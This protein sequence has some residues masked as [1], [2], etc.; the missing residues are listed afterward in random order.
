MI[1]NFSCISFAFRNLSSI[2]FDI[3]AQQHDSTIVAKHSHQMSLN[4]NSL[5]KNYQ[6]IQC[7]HQVSTTSRM[8]VDI[9]QLI[10]SILFPSTDQE[11]VQ[12]DI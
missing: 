9:V 12:L 3:E 10:I 5:L 4:S 8:T 7:L 2:E 6:S 1:W 11:T